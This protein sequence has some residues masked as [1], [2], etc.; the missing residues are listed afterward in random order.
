GRTLVVADFHAGGRV[1]DPRDPAAV[2]SLP[3]PGAV[4][5]DVS[6]DGRW[7]TTSTHHGFGSKVWELGTGS[8]LDLIPERRTATL[9]FSPDGR[10]LAT[11]T[12]TEVCVRTVG[13]WEVVRRVRRDGGADYPGRAAFS[14]DGRVLAVTLGPSAVQLLDPVGGRELVRLQ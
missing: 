9:T 10:W 6:P 13:S 3:H 1:V 4:W 5:A 2:R 14:R 11:A 7:A 12:G 8:R